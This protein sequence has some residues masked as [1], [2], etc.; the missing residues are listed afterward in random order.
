VIYVE[1]RKLAAQ[2]P[3]VSSKLPLMTLTVPMHVT[4]EPLVDY[5]Y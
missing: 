3:T 5:G 4:R 2:N 1:M